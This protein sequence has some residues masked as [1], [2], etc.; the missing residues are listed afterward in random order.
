MELTEEVKAEILRHAAQESPKECCGLL[1]VSDGLTRYVPC[2]NAARFPEESFEIPAN[3]WISAEAFGE[4]A[5]V[6]HSHPNGELFLSAPDR[7]AQEMT[8]LPWVLAVSGGLK[9]VPPVPP[10]LGRVFEYGKSDCYT[11]LSDAY[12]LAGIVLPEVER[13]TMDD[14]RRMQKFLLLAEDAGFYKVESPKAGDVI[15]TAYRG[16]AAHAMLYLGQGEVL[17]HECDMLSRSE[18][19]SP[20]MQRITHSVWRHKGWLP[21]MVEAVRNDLFSSR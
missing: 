6:V 3:D 8:K 20:E 16:H 11:L 14:D 7:K 2:R 4:I 21:P 15:L 18:T 9:V 1:A 10:L 12:L 17:H 19:Y 13:G 5:A